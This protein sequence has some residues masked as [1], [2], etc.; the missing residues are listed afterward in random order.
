MFE[1]FIVAQDGS[2]FIF[3]MKHPREW[4]HGYFA[5]SGVAGWL[6]S[7]TDPQEAFWDSQ[8]WGKEILFMVLVNQVDQPDQDPASLME[9]EWAGLPSGLEWTEY[10][11]DGKKIA[12]AI[13][14]EPSM[15]TL[16]AAVID[17]PVG[18]QLFGFFPLAA[19]VMIRQ[20]IEPIL[21]SLSWQPAEDD[22]ISGSESVDIRHEGPLGPGSRQSGY[23]PLTVRTRTYGYIPQVSISEWTLEGAA[24][25]EIDISIKTQ[26]PGTTLM[27]NVV[28]NAG[29]SLLDG[30]PQAFTGALKL[31]ALP[32]PAGGIYRIQVYTTVDSGE[33]GWY[34]I[35]LD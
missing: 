19:E 8:G 28:D 12:Y 14:T 30:G 32:L 3:S 2:V 23:V 4:A 35:A 29:N 25:Q 22:D 6:F 31:G 16:P 27:A 10:E 34:D 15:G 9:Q 33:Y 26:D 1:S 13:S 17:Y 18:I 21:N 11:Q 20:Q 5:D 24:G 7:T